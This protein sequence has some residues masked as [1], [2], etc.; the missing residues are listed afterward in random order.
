MAVTYSVSRSVHIPLVGEAGKR[1]P[2]ADELVDELEH[3][4]ARAEQH[5][6]GALVVVDGATDLANEVEHR[7]AEHGQDLTALLARI[8]VLLLAL[9]DVAHLA[10]D[11]VEGWRKGS[12]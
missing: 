8:E 6:D 4:V 1:D 3:L 2:L 9:L 10:V 11:H 12:R 5:H 7:R